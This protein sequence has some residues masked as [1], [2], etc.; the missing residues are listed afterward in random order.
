MPSLAGLAHLPIE[1]TNL[2]ASWP[3][4]LAVYWALS[5]VPLH[6]FAAILAIKQLWPSYGDD[7]P[8]V[9]PLHLKGAKECQGLSFGWSFACFLI[10]WQ[11]EAV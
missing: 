7:G 5:T 2:V 3:P 1:S 8:P 11:Q 6:K 10:S 9:F 4:G